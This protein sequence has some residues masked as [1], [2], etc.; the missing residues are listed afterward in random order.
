MNRMRKII[1]MLML[2][3]CYATSIAVELTPRQQ[4]EIVEK[5]NV[6]SRTL[7]SL[8]CSFVQTKNLS[9]LNEQMVSEGKMYYSR[10]GKLRWEYTSPYKYLFILKGT[11]VYVGNESRKDIIDTNTNKIFKEVARLMM[12]TVTGTAI[13]NSTDFKIDV[14]DGDKV[15]RVTLSPKKREL[16]AMFSKIEMRFN[17]SDMVISEITLFEKKG[18]RTDLRFTSIST[19]RVIDESVFDIS[20]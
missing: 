4:E 17:K 5:I 2:S 12:S 14:A 18:D 6:A 11:S 10:H 15:W 20:E 13:A 8:D 1:A 9:L 3:V 19:N 16:K 7:T